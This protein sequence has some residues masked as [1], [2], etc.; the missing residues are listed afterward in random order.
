MKNFFDPIYENL[1]LQSRRQLLQRTG[2]GIGGAAL[3]SL[4][5]GGASA[6][7]KGNDESGLHHIA[8]AKRVIYLFQSG[9]PSQMDLWDYK[10]DLV[11]RRGVDLPDSVRMVTGVFTAF[12]GIVVCARLGWFCLVM[13]FISEI[14]DLV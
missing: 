12:S 9:G 6:S 13:A 14:L 11:A 10:P 2:V 1:S 4:L 3:S 8:K 7:E 5:H